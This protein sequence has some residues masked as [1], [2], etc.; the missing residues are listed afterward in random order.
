MVCPALSSGGRSP[1]SPNRP[2]GTLGGSGRAET[3]SLP[4]CCSCSSGS[5]FKAVTSHAASAR[6]R[7]R[8]GAI[9]AVR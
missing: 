3:W 7:A 9:H 5:A 6:A 8:W 1:S 4:L 2:N